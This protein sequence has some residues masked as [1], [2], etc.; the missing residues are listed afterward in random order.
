MQNDK[1]NGYIHSLMIV[2]IAT[3]VIVGGLAVGVVHDD[4][5]DD[6]SSYKEVRYLLQT[7]E[8]GH[9]IPL[10]GHVHHLAEPL[11]GG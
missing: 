3:A 1:R 10:V 5:Q 7:I 6:H 8:K 4:E 11:H 2:G 9:T